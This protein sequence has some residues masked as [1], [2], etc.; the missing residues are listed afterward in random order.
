M[1]MKGRIKNWDD[2]RGFGF[3]VPDNGER[4]IFVHITGFVE[5]GIRPVG[6]EIVTYK[7]ST[8][9][10]GRPCAVSV[11]YVVDERPP[12]LARSYE[13]PQ[14][15]ARSYL[16]VLPI[17]I[18]VAFVSFLVA[19]TFSRR[20]PLWL[21]AV[22]P[23]ASVIAFRMYAKDKQAAEKRKWRTAERKLLLVAL[24]GGWPG[25]VA[26]QQWFRHKTSKFSFQFVFWMLVAYNGAALAYLASPDC[27]QVVR[28]AI[29]QVRVTA[30]KAWQSLKPAEPKRTQKKGG[31][32][33]RVPRT[34]QK[35]VSAASNRSTLLY[36]HDL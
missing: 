5:R 11:E 15:V 33:N 30:D 22:Y 24:L 31:S 28:E 9:H 7:K 8:D 4:S 18:T 36:Q 2:D 21:F 12:D 10:L 1:R 25:A 6:G 32:K 3:I 34:T 19:E 13:P 16:D 35:S 20:V 23:L 17:S 29:E 14:V 27:R 26:A